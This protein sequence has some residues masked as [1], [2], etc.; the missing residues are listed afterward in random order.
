MIKVNI[1]IIVYPEEWWV[2][3]LE[4]AQFPYKTL[5]FGRDLILKVVRIY[6]DSEGDLHDTIECELWG[7]AEADS[8]VLKSHGFKKVD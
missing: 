4:V 3:E 1:K 6:W 5:H 2:R 8:E 7:G